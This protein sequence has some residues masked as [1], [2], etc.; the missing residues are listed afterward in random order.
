MIHLLQLGVSWEF[1]HDTSR[2]LSVPAASKKEKQRIKGKKT[3]K[4][5]QQYD[6]QK[7]EI[8]SSHIVP[9]VLKL[10]IEN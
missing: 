6:Q 5:N 9:P 2:A 10:G 1:P 4:T 3:T 7:I 8:Q